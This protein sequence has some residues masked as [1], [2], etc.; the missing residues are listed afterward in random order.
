MSD[1]TD[2][3]LD[4]DL[5][6]RDPD[7]WLSSRFVTDPVQRARLVA[8]YTLDGEW[9]RV[10]AAAKTPLAGEIRFAWWRE[11]LERFVA[12]G[13]AEHP[14]IGALG[15]QAAHDLQGLLQQVIDARVDDLEGE[16]SAAGDIALMAA[17][18]RLLHP[19]TPDGATH[20]A[21]RAWFAARA[22]MDEEA[23]RNLEIAG[24]A[25]KA[26]PV[27]AFPAVAHVALVPAYAEGQRPGEL[28]KRL[29]ITWAVLRGRL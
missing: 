21:A 26:I 20:H 28:G 7:R 8:L 25:S 19:A 14:A 12:S 2:P 22:G 4:A 16:Q 24:Q 3:T 11:A 9:S 5:H 18:A 15:A 27:A 23:K 1:L 13:A 17:A 6:R 29:R 10:K